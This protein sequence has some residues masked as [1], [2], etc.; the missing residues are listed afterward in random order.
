MTEY[1]KEYIKEVETLV[2]GKVTKD[3]VEDLYK[4]ITFFQHERL[5]HLIVT[6]FFVLFTL[7]FLVLCFKNTL[8]LIPTIILLIMIVFYILHYYFLEN[9]VQKLYKIY[10]KMNSKVI[11][12]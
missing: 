5:I 3:D 12:K 4:K 10:D 1:L 2:K 7:V 9:S 11:S 6:M 8:F